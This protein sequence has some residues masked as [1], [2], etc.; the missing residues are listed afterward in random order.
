MS[1]N[2]LFGFA[3]VHCVCY[4]C[5]ELQLSFKRKL[6]TSEGE[7]KRASREKALQEGER[8][9]QERESFRRERESSKRERARRER[10]LQARES[11]EGVS[12]GG[13][14]EEHFINE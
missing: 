7:R 13:S 2:K 10:E 6:Q 1:L 11:D 12:L 5:C 14:G 3:F 9:L 4:G 8:E